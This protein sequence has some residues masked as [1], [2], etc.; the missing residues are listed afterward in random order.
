MALIGAYFGAVLV[1]ASAL[2][3]ISGGV[4]DKGADISP[5]RETGFTWIAWAVILG[6]VLTALYD[7]LS[8]R[9]AL[10]TSGVLA[11]FLSL[12]ALVN[13]GDMA[14]IN[15]QEDTR[16]YNQAG[17]ML[18]NFDDTAGG[19]LGRCTVLEDLR[20][21]APSESEVRRMDLIEIYMNSAAANIYGSTFCDPGGN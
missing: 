10:V 7:L 6:V 19:N 11:V 21:L 15:T 4:Q 2:A 9:W 14:N 20:S 8:D 5:W 18:V 17:L 1:L 13:Q 3:S 12:T 16:L